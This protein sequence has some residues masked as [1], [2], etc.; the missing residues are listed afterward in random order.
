MA[1][2]APGLDSPAS[3]VVYSGGFSVNLLSKKQV[4]R[5][6]G[7]LPWTAELY[8][9]L[10]QPGKP[11]T[12]SFSLRRVENAL[13]GWLAQAKKPAEIL[14]SAYTLEAGVDI[15]DTPLLD[16]AWRIIECYLAG[17]GSD[18]T[19]YLPYAIT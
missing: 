11:L 2:N 13:P 8:W 15:L 5:V 6:L 3:I 19:C 17:V 18:V 10:R 4:K 16:R 14:A 12:K 1:R 7:E 9:Q